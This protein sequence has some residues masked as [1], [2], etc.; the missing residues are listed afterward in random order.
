MAEV[1]AW[2][3]LH[4]ERF[5]LEM[6]IASANQDGKPFHVAY[7]QRIAEALRAMATDVKHLVGEDGA[8]RGIVLGGI[9][10]K[11]VHWRVVV[12]FGPGQSLE[13]QKP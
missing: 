8:I 10:D 2:E 12:W 7:D 5:A 3:T 6:V 11:T 4:P 9:F 1:N 13:E